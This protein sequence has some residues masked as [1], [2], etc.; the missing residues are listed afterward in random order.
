MAK[1]GPLPDAPFCVKIRLLGTQ[2]GV[3][4]ANI[5]H[6]RYAGGTIDTAAC[7]ALATTV[8]TAWNTNLAP[9]VHAFTVL[10]TVEVTDISTRTGAQGVDT[11]GSTGTQAGTPSSNQV[12]LVGSLKIAQRY[13]GG[14][15][16][17]YIPGMVTANITGGTTFT[18]TYITSMQTALRAIRTAINGSSAGGATWNMV[19]VS[20]FHKVGG[21]EA[22]KIPPDIYVIT[23]CVV[24]TRVDT[25]RRRLGKETT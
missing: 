9:L 10:K 21:A 18:S 5:L 6:A 14:H 1:L 13:R 24:H 7:Q 12:A 23:D 19:A 3:V 8:R 11:V 17:I 20:Y 2:N 16:R 4:W 22:Y 25:V 15:P